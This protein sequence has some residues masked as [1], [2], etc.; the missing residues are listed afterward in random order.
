MVPGQVHRSTIDYLS[1]L[2]MHRKEG[3]LLLLSPGHEWLYDVACLVTSLM[4]LLRRRLTPY[5]PS[6][7][8]QM[9]QLSGSFKFVFLKCR[10]ADA[11]VAWSL[12]SCQQSGPF[13][14]KPTSYSRDSLSYSNGNVGKTSVDATRAKLLSSSQFKDRQLHLLKM[15]PLRKRWFQ[16]GWYLSSDGCRSESQGL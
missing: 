5:F 16:Q 15:P 13:H 4:W 6:R 8:F 3:G 12:L 1:S 2:K 9:H 14:N 11:T 10:I 7:H